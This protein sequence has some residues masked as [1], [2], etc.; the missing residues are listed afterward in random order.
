MIE[1]PAMQA[2]GESAWQSSPLSLN[3]AVTL[4]PAELSRS[5]PMGEALAFWIRNNPQHLFAGRT[6][7]LQ[8]S[9][10]LLAQSFQL[11]RDGDREGA[12]TLAVTAYLEGFELIEAALSNVDSDL[13][14]RAEA[15]MIAYRQGITRS[16]SPQELQALYD[17]A[18]ALLKESDTA[19]SG[20]ALSPSVAFSGSLIILL[21]EGLEIILVLAAIITF[22]VKSERSDALTYVHAGWVLALVAGVGTWAV[23]N[24]LFTISGST[25]E[26][27]EGVTA[28]IASAILLYVGFWMHR[29]ASA[30][31]W[32]QYLHSK[33]RTALDK[34]TLWTLA[35]V[36]F[37]AVYREIFE[38]ILFYQALWAQVAAEAHNA[39]FYGAVLAF[40]LLLL[41][42]W[43]IFRFGMRMPL[44]QFFN[45]SAV[46]VVTLAFIFAGKGVAAL[47]EAGSLPA[48]PVSIPTIE[49]LGIY[50]NL[51]A[52]ALQA[53]I[54]LVTIIAVVYERA[55]A[56][57]A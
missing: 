45:I 46:L 12:Q 27:T 4:S 26:I 2:D 54:V 35:L 19:L 34:R 25:R 8:V 22:L 56:K 5:R 18:I 32:T 47:Q 39:V 14:R 36:S 20:E 43:L 24:Y 41:T 50:P 38:I 55:Q 28:L 23:S 40:V 16:V 31:R 6:E 15:G 42:T 13:M 11:Y 44:K 21:R 1:D 7:P 9:R 10:D 30:R 3:D 53:L 29:N 37:L 33:I 17:S 51:Q 52:L 49:L 57:T 48:T